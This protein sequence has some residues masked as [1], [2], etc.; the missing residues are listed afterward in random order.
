MRIMTV[1]IVVGSILLHLAAA[2]HASSSSPRA[3]PW[4]YEGW[5]SFPS[6]WFG[7]NPTGIIPGE[8]NS[9]LAVMARHQLV[10]WGW[11]QGMY[12]IPCS[13]AT[14]QQCAKDAVETLANYTKREGIPAIPSFPYRNMNAALLNFEDINRALNC[15]VNWT[16]YPHNYQACGLSDPATERLR[17]EWFVHDTQGRVCGARSGTPALQMTWRKS[18]PGALEYWSSVV[19]GWMEANLSPAKAIFLDVVDNGADWENNLNSSQGNCT[20]GQIDPKQWNEAMALNEV[21]ATITAVRDIAAKLLPL[22]MAVIINAGARL[23][24]DPAK[25]LMPFD[26]FFSHFADIPNILWCDSF[27]PSTTT[28]R[29]DCCG[30]LIPFMMGVCRY[31]EAWN[32]TQDLS[33]A[34]FM[35]KQAMPKII[36]WFGS[37]DTQLEN[38]MAAFFVAQSAH[39]YFSMSREWT[40]GGWNWHPAYASTKCGK[41]MGDAV[42]KPAGV[43]SR[44]F[45]S[46]SVRLDLDC[47]IASRDGCGTVKH[48][49]KRVV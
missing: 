31:F 11:Q 34:L 45:E 32:S 22:D 30:T 43:F 44:E 20:V 16:T 47:D 46:C 40:D 15:T 3:I 39:D 14:G 26:K 8:S 41:P 13:I 49:A 25:A 17:R 21:E 9:T 38:Q 29:C 23:S 1:A 19:A 5:N 6:N 18:A 35:Q 24:H 33:T 48:T 28:M 27:I 4:K 36:H 12:D 2:A 10:G 42:E 7:A 37:N